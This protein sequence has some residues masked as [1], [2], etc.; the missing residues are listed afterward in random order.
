MGPLPSAAAVSTTPA[1]FQL[2]PGS[3]CCTPRLVSPRFSEVAVTRTATSSRSCHLPSDIAQARARAREGPVFRK[4][5]AGAPRVDERLY[6][7]ITRDV[8]EHRNF[9]RYR[10][11]LDVLFGLMRATANR[12][13]IN[14]KTSEIAWYS[15]PSPRRFSPQSARCPKTLEKTR[16]F[17]SC[18]RS[19]S[20]AMRFS[21]GRQRLP[22]MRP[23]TL[24]FMWQIT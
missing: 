2:G 18:M 4:C 20:P 8:A 13:L 7:S 12:V 6:H 14:R 22:R 5:C 16:W 23:S 9:R 1:K 19:N 21:L 11:L 17:V 15:S 3:A 24:E 10:H